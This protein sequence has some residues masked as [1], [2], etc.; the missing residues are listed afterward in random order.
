MSYSAGLAKIKLPSRGLSSGSKDPYLNYKS[1]SNDL[2]QS[3]YKYKFY[4]RKFF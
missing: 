1:Y 4:C 2:R 3:N